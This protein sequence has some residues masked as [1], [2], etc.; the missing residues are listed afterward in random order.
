MMGKMWGVLTWEQGPELQR[1]LVGVQGDL[2]LGGFGRSRR[3]TYQSQRKREP[4]LE[5]LGNP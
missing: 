5:N 1:W 4:A 2:Q 3:D